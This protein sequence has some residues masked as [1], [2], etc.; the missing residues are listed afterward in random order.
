MWGLEWQKEEG[1]CSRISKSREAEKNMLWNRGA[2][3][4]VNRE[5]WR[6]FLESSGDFG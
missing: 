3:T 4:M 6:G 5:V 2:Y 1:K